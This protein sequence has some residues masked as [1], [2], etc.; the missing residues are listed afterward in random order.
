MY[1]YQHPDAITV[2]SLQ[3]RETYDD[4]GRGLLRLVP[5]GP[6]NIR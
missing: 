5:P 1:W 3:V 2:A 4:G 6:I